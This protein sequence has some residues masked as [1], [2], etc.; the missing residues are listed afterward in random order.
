MRPDRGPIAM[1]QRRNSSTS[2]NS[3]R[4]WAG[5]LAG[6][7]YTDPDQTPEVP[8]GATRSPTMARLA[9]IS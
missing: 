5:N 1:V 8:P 7:C 3:R 9:A 2:R 4:V 6:R